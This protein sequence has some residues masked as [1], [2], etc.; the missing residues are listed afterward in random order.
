MLNTKTP[1]CGLREAVCVHKSCNKGHGASRY[2][3]VSRYWRE[4]WP[5]GEIDWWRRQSD[6]SMHPSRSTQT[7]T[8]HPNNPNSQT[9]MCGASRAAEGRKDLSGAMSTDLFQN[10]GCSTAI[11]REKPLLFRFENQGGRR[12][13]H[14]CVERDFVT[15]LER[16]RRQTRLCASIVL[17]GL[18]AM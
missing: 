12:G 16:S 13:S 11:G 2:L 15:L 5:S 8:H 6:C 18:R 1:R 10:A 9:W 7:I 3:R 4:Q 17:W 14:F